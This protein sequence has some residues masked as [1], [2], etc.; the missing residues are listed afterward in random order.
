MTTGL[1]YRVLGSTD[2]VTT[3]DVCAKPELKGTVLLT[4]GEGAA[5]YAGSSCA[6]RLAGRPVASIRTEKVAA[7][8][9]RRAA[10]ATH[11]EAR[12][13]YF[14]ALRDAALGTSV[15]FAAIS[16]WS[17]RPETR[18]ALALWDAENPAPR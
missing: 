12:S 17:E 7:D 8:K 13:A 10:L 3:C 14:S 9:A 4:D 6:A 16:E 2:D 11:R 18:A 5:I 1:H 15:N